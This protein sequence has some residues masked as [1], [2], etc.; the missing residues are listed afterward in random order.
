MPRHI[1]VGNTP[2]V[3][4]EAVADMSLALVLAAQRRLV[5]CDRM[6]RSAEG[7]LISNMSL[8]GRDCLG[9]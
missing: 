7:A 5:E 9:T 1:P 6:C 2:D 8:L 3:L 4:T